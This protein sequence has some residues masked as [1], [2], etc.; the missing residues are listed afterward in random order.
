MAVTNANVK[1][2][3]LQVASLEKALKGKVGGEGG[4]VRGWE[5]ERGLRGMGKGRVMSFHTLLQD[6]EKEELAQICD[7]LMKELRN[8]E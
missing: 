1:K 7:D 3:Q 5:G 2:L 4:R 8:R 6:Q